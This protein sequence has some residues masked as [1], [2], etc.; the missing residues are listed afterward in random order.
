MLEGPPGTTAQLPPALADRYRLL[1]PEFVDSTPTKRVS[2]PLAGF[3]PG[4]KIS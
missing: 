1:F 3:P 4:R 2:A